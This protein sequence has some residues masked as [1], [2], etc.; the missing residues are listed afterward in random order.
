MNPP[1][2]TGTLPLQE[3]RRDTP[4]GWAPGDPGYPLRLYLEKL[5]LWY[6]TT[7]AEDEVVGPL[8]A[9]RLHGRAAKVA[10][11]LRIP[12][13]DG[14]L[15]IGPDALS[16]LAV[17]EVVDPNTG[18]I[19]QN[20]IA[21]GVQYLMHALRQAFGQRDQDLATAALDK[22]FGLTRQGQK[23]SLAEYAVEFETRYD[24][25]QDRSRLS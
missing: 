1:T 18:A 7:T 4:P 3:F 21:S 10:M 22:F 12:R 13:P 20:H 15:D 25:A 16:R 24:E 2:S 14:Q 8:I 6:K 5:Q 19:I 11:S 9:G 17:D 23:M